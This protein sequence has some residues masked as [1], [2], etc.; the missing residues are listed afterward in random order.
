MQKNKVQLIKKEYVKYYPFF[1]FSKTKNVTKNPAGDI[2]D[3][4]IN[5]HFKKLELCSLEPKTGYFRDGYCKSSVYDVGS[6]SICA[7]MTKDFLEQ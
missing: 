4:H 1:E 3:G 5:V 2:D 7:K 6:H